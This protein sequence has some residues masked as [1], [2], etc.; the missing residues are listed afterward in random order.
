LTTLLP[1]NENSWPKKLT[2]EDKKQIKDSV[3]RAEGIKESKELRS[4]NSGINNKWTYAKFKFDN[5]E[6]KFKI[7]GLETKVV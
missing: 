2:D 4:L 5:T 1:A 7:T 6:R 3:R